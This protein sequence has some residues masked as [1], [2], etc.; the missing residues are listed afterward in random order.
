M[1]EFRLER[2]AKGLIEK[3]LPK[4]TSVHHLISFP[5]FCDRW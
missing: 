3:L 4:L 5:A 1:S 2:G